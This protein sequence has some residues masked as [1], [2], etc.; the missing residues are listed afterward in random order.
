MVTLDGERPGRVRE[1]G[2]ENTEACGEIDGVDTPTSVVD[3]G[4]G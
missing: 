4:R 2:E 1:D 3:W